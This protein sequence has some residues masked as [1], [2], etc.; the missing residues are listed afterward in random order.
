MKSDK[1]AVVEIFSGAGGLGHGF[2]QA[3]WSVDIAIDFDPIACETYKLNHPTTKVWCMDIADVTG[4]RIRAEVGDR[5]IILIGGPS[6]QSWSEMQ[7]DIPGSR[8]GLDDPRGQMIYQYLRIAKE[9]QPVIT[10]FENVSN[11]VKDKHVQEFNRFKDRLYDATGLNLEHRILNAFDYGV[12]QL[13]ERVI[14]IGTKS[15]ITNPFQFLKPIEGPKSLRAQLRDCPSSEYAQFDQKAAEIMKKIPAGKCWNVLPPAEAIQAL[16]KDYRAICNVCNTPFKPHETL[17]TCP[18]CKGIDYRNGFGVTSYWRRLAW[19]K[20][21][22]TICTVLPTK[23]HGTLAHPEENRGLSVR[24]CARIQGFPDSY[25]FCGTMKDAYRQIGNA[26]PVT[27]GQ[28]IGLAVKSSL[29]NKR[30]NVA[31]WIGKLQVH[32]KK[33]ILTSLERDFLNSVYVKWRNQE[34]IPEKY[35]TYLE[36]TYSRLDAI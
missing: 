19:N 25:T 33:Q 6:C 27:L 11:M 7:E 21:S 18:K 1:Y 31:E 9:L 32:P 23:A 36:D 35:M 14:L 30:S 3:G 4:K 16:G 24:E 13:R 29:A 20:P 26:V 28:A 10:V 22:Y 15:G 8:K 17:N 2:T 12:A 5:E 34:S